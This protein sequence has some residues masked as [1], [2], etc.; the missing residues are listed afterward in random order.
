VGL[1]VSVV[2]ARLGLERVQPGVLRFWGEAMASPFGFKEPERE[3]AAQVVALAA[4]DA[5][6]G[7]E[8]STALVQEHGTHVCAARAEAFLEGPWGRDLV[9]F[10]LGRRLRASEQG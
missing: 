8:C 6:A 7:R 4:R 10:A 9:R 1:W 3:L 2:S 5:R